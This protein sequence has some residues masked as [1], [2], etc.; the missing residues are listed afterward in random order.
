[1][2]A[3]CAPRERVHSWHPQP[4]VPW[5]YVSAQSLEPVRNGFRILIPQP[6][7]ALFPA[8]IG[9]TRVAIEPPTGDLFGFNDPLI[10]RSVRRLYADPRNEFLQW[11]RAF[12]ELMAISE[13][14]PIKER[15]L[16]GGPAEP[17]QILAAFNA[18][19]A[20]LGLIYA[21]NEKTADQAEMFGVLYEAESG[22]Q[23]AVIHAEAESLVP[24]DE[25]VEDSE[26]NLWETDA[27]A[28]VRQRFERLLFAC[29]RTLIRHDQPELI[30]APEGWKPAEPSRPVEW[31]PRF[32]NADG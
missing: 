17:G 10:A 11:N 4:P 18:L 24:F 13:V 19:H 7:T 15:D 28:I 5:E 20:K 8:S 23:L 9:V 12:D 25:R 1:M 26:L 30:E 27:R 3:G 22:R 21:V 16:G 2:L 31:P 29:L 6:T 14:F 32:R